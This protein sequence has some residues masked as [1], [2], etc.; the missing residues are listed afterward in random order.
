M[1]MLR[2]MVDLEMKNKIQI[3]EN[4]TETDIIKRQ[5][6][7]TLLELKED[8]EN[9]NLTKREQRRF[10]RHYTALSTGII[11]K[12]YDCQW[13]QEQYRKHKT[14]LQEFLE[15]YVQIHK[16]DKLLE[17]SEN[18]NNPY[19]TFRP[20]QTYYTTLDKKNAIEIYKIPH[21]NRK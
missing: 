4:I 7:I 6:L 3:K 10:I 8:M 15:D 17:Y 2:F 1:H 20:E 14:S 11:L 13:I 12:R 16:L 5:R 18:S 21:K 9:N 19:E